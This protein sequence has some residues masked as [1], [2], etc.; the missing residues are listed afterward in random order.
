MRACAI[1]S[2]SSL[3]KNLGKSPLPISPA[4]TLRVLLVPQVKCYI[5]TYDNNETALKLL[6]EKLLGQSGFKG[7]SPVDA[8]CGLLDTRI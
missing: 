1:I 4:K 6:V 5:N 7:A 8:F 2:S 3:V